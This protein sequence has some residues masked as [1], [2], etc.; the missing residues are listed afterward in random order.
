MHRVRRFNRLS[1]P[2]EYRPNSPLMREYLQSIS[3]NSGPDSEGTG[4][5][6]CVVICVVPYHPCRYLGYL[7]VSLCHS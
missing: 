4:S 5:L 3:K 2:E 1:I 7:T 6:R